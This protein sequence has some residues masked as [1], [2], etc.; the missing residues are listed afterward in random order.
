MGFPTLLL[1][2]LDIS[3]AHLTAAVY[4]A[5]ILIKLPVV[6]LHQ[7]Q[8]AD[9]SRQQECSSPSMGSAL[10]CTAGHGTAW[11]W[12]GMAAGGSSTVVGGTASP[13]PVHVTQRGRPSA[14]L[15]GE[16]QAD[17]VLGKGLCTVPCFCAR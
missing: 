7:L 5:E 13:C 2:S 3:F 16:G 10:H 8:Q 12:A 11:L 14:A 4:G 1:M 6:K 9:S 17:A 15:E